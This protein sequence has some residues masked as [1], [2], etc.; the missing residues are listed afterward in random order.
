MKGCGQRADPISGSCKPKTEMVRTRAGFFRIG[1]D[2]NKL[3]QLIFKGR[4]GA[5]T[6]AL[7]KILLSQFS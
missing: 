3:L 6:K 2:P 4:V 5:N 7:F 1:L